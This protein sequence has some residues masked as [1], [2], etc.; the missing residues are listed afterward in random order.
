MRIRHAFIFC[1][2]LRVVTAIEPVDV[3][4]TVDESSGA[5]NIFVEGYPEWPWLRNGVV[6]VRNDGQVWTSNSEDHHLL[7]MTKHAT[8]SGQDAIGDFDTNTW[9]ANY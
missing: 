5:F 6:A 3:K 8:G 4:V 7:K 2:F 1:V 9:V